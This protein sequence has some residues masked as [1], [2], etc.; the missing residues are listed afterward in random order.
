VRAAELLERFRPEAIE[1]TLAR[2]VLP[3]LVPGAG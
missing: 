2:E 3:A 1:R